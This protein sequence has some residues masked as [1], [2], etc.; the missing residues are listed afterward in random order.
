[1]SKYIYCVLRHFQAETIPFKNDRE[2]YNF[3]EDYL[4]F[5]SAKPVPWSDIT[6]VN[7]TD[8]MNPIPPEY[9]LYTGK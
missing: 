6:H 8:P 9:T 5:G 3:K 1:M 4:H 2:R 7:Y